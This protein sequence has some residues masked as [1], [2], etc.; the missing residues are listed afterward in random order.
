MSLRRTPRRSRSSF[1]S[2]GRCTTATAPRTRPARP[3]P[4]PEPPSRT[5]PALCRGPGDGFLSHDE[6]RAALQLQRA[7]LGWDDAYTQARAGTRGGAGLLVAAQAPRTRRPSAAGVG[8][9]RPR[10]GAARAARHPPQGALQR[11]ARLVRAASALLGARAVRGAPRGGAAGG[12]MDKERLRPL[13]EM[14]ALRARVALRGA[15]F[16]CECV[17]STLLWIM[18]TRIIEK[19][20][21]LAFP[22]STLP[23]FHS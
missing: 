19:A 14:S 12:R 23:L 5:P 3:R 2:C 20:L 1:A 11:A 8:G 17:R 9:V 16:L 10:C 13:P 15:V 4:L 21:V 7:R 22:S 6:L 18:H